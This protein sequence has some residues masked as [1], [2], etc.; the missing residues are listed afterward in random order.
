M[1]I[2]IHIHHKSEMLFKRW[3]AIAHLIRFIKHAKAAVSV[4]SDFFFFFSV[5]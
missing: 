3:E 2:L 1:L 4:I 5:K